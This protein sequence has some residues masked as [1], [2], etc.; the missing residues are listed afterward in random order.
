MSELKSE[1]EQITSGSIIPMSD[2]FGET[3][4]SASNTWILYHHLEKISNYIDEPDIEI[5]RLIIEPLIEELDNIYGECNLSQLSDIESTQVFGDLRR[6]VSSNLSSLGLNPT[7]MLKVVILDLA[8]N[9]PLQYSRDDQ[10]RRWA[11]DL[12]GEKSEWM[13]FAYLDGIMFEET[14]TVQEFNFSSNPNAL[15][16][17]SEIAVL[18]LSEPHTCVNLNQNDTPPPVFKA[19][20]ANEIY[21]IFYQLSVC[22]QLYTGKC[23]RLLMTH[24]RPYYSSLRDHQHK[25]WITGAKLAVEYHTVSSD[26]HE[27]LNRFISE[28]FPILNSLRI[29]QN[30]YGTDYRSIAIK[31]FS[32]A[33][34]RNDPLERISAAVVSLEALYGYEHTELL[35]RLKQ[36]IVRLISPI[37]SDSNQILSTITEAYKIR[38]GYLH[39]NKPRPPQESFI[40]TLL[41]ILSKSIFVILKIDMDKEPFVRMIDEAMI[42][43]NTGIALSEWVSEIY[44]TLS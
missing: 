9:T 12:T 43:N 28:F 42:D 14:L 37:L 2:L 18:P 24:L 33:V 44:E 20:S 26:Q 11:S 27:S 13:A 22:F 32:D 5:R 30:H 10:I 15:F 19:K 25:H 4:R 8:V 1:I 31:H 34:L 29:E 36:R 41:E 16:S 6:Y 39:G 35:Y 38:S 7:K 21:L 40:E 23:V 3:S 17:D